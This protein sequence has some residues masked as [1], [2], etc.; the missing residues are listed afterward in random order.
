LK[1][2]LGQGFFLDVFAMSALAGFDNSTIQL[3]W[4]DVTSGVASN[5][6]ILYSLNT[7]VT[8]IGSLSYN[9]QIPFYQ[10]LFQFEFRNI[11]D[12]HDTLQNAAI[13]TTLLVILVVDI[14]MTMLFFKYR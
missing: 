4:R 7:N 1:A 3:I 10:R 2:I 5:A 14:I 9:V 13:L 6:T 11:D 8:A 12:G